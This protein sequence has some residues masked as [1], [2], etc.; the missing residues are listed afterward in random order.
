M[1]SVLNPLLS[2]WS[3]VLVFMA[4]DVH[5]PGNS[6]PLKCCKM[7]QAAGTKNQKLFYQNF[8]LAFIDTQT[9]IPW[10]LLWLIFFFFYSRTIFF[11]FGSVIKS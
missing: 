9:N 10:L 1:G 7:Y 5:W 6:W 2:L 4:G 11:L 3:H 8:S